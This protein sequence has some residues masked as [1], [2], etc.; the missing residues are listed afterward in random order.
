LFG[1]KSFWEISAFRVGKL[2]NDKIFSLHSGKFVD[3]N[4]SNIKTATKLDQIT[5]IAS[6]PHRFVSQL[7]AWRMNVS[8]Y[9]PF[10]AQNDDDTEENEFFCQSFSSPS[11]GN[12]EG[13]FSVKKY[14]LNFFGKTCKNGF[15]DT[16]LSTPR[17]AC[18]QR[19][20]GDRGKLR[21]KW[22]S[23]SEW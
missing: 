4:S 20:H 3:F 7:R 16:F 18:I 5:I 8:C 21:G 1:V 13:K 15:V 23:R 10:E 9:H 2:P 6:N 14:F 17:L 12:L 11:C 22:K 19:K